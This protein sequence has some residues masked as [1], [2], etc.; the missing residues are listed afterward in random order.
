M[1]R[2]VLRLCLRITPELISIGLLLLQSQPG[3]GRPHGKVNAPPTPPLYRLWGEQP[4]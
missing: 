3:S 2:A 1:G 4:C